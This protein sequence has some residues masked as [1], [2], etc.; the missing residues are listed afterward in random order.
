MAKG[1]LT[2]RGGGAGEPTPPPNINF[3]SATGT[4][5][6]FTI[7]NNSIR[8]RDITYGLTTPPT[9]TTI[10][11]AENST[12]AEQTISGLDPSTAYIIYAQAED[13]TIIEATL[14]TV[15]EPIQATGGTITDIDDYRYHVFTSTGTST[16]S[17]QDTGGDGKIDYL[18]VAGGGGGGR[19]VGGGGGAGGLIFKQNE[20]ISVQNYSI[21]VG[22]GG[23]GATANTNIGQKGANSTF[24]SLTAL[25]GGPGASDSANNA[26]TQSGG[27]GGGCE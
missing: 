27:S 11:I 13:S 20:S 17:V 12:S 19:R 24:F 9:T 22:N 1:I 18:I 4:S 2:R 3:V 14:E 15:F 16:F 25:G 10:N 21:S 6:T 23:N 7:T 5:I 8:D 26:S